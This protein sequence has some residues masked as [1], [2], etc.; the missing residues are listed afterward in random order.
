MLFLMFAACLV[1]WE[2]YEQ[3]KAE[4]TDNDGDG[5]SEADGDCDD[6]R[7]TVAPTLDER[8]DGVDNDCDG[9]VD[10]ADAMD[11]SFWYRDADGDGAGELT[12]S[13]RACSAPAGFV[14]QG[15]DCDDSDA[16]LA[17]GLSEVPYDG[18]DNDCS[19]GDL[20]DV[21]G[22]GVDA[23]AAGGGDCDDSDP[24]IYPGAPE[25]WE[26]GA[27]DNAPKPQNPF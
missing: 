22:D 1:D 10:E 14:A 13:T 21:D 26:N 16:E 5:V 7:D 8:C 12:E 19:G 17:P 11:A 4:L 18:R 20:T 23:T 24:S 25:T 15:D 2:T 9:V 6:S 3:R 27:T